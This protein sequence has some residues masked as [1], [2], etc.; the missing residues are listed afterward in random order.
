VRAVQVGGGLENRPLELGLP[1]TLRSKAESLVIATYQFLT[2]H[3]AQKAHNFTAQH[4]IPR[5]AACVAL[6]TRIVSNPQNASYLR[7]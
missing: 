3:S 7:D 4:F 6:Q 2:G 5:L 1:S